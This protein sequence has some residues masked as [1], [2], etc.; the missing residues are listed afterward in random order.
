[1]KQERMEPE[2]MVKESNVKPPDM[3]GEPIKFA[4][5][6]LSALI[7]KLRQENA[8]LIAAL[9]SAKAKSEEIKA[10]AAEKPATELAAE[11]AQ[12]RAALEKVNQENS[13]LEQ[14]LLAEK[15]KSAVW[16][17]QITARDQ[18]KLD[19]P[20]VEARLI[21]EH[22]SLKKQ[23]ESERE[24]LINDVTQSREEITVLEEKISDAQQRAAQWR[25]ELDVR[26]ADERQKDAEHQQ[27]LAEKD[28]KIKELESRILQLRPVDGDAPLKE[29]SEAIIKEMQQLKEM[30]ARSASREKLLQYELSKVRA[31]AIGLE[32]ICE[33]QQRLMQRHTT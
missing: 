5:N 10:D 16:E 24:K 3:S 1:M 2:P 8:E 30:V 29:P 9:G 28:A 19:A 33:S 22:A 20:S 32:K 7:D 4:G 26:L 25:A 17:Q 31:Q 18:T 21:K 14:M 13:R 11:L 15:Q 12:A 27:L 23:F 6:D